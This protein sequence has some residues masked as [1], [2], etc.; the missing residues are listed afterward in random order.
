MLDIHKLMRI[1]IR[2]RVRIQLINFDAVPDFDLM[3]IRIKITKM[4]RILADPDPQYC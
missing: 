3:R 1:R 2:Y 4:M